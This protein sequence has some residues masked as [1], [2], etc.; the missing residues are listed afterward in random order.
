MYWGFVFN[1]VDIVFNVEDKLIN[2]TQMARGFKGKQ[3][4]D[5]TRL[6]STKQFIDTLMEVRGIP[7]AA[8][9]KAYPQKNLSKIMKSK[10]MVD[11]GKALRNS[12]NSEITDSRSVDYELVKVAK[13]GNDLSKQGTWIHPKLALR[14]AQKLDPE[15]AIWIDTKIA[16]LFTKGYAGLNPEITA[17]LDKLVSNLLYSYI[18]FYPHAFIIQVFRF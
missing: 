10:E 12:I 4:S 7:R 15:F 17:K 13:G 11:Y 1:G 14:L 2:A 9:A 5:W 3:V 18:I 16:E 6:K 8:V